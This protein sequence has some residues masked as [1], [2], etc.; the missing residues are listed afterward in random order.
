M[1]GSVAHLPWDTPHFYPTI[2]FISAISC[3]CVSTSGSG[4]SAGHRECVRSLNSLCVYVCVSFQ[5][6]KTTT[7]WQDEVEGAAV[8]LVTEGE[9]PEEGLV[10]SEMDPHV[11]DRQTSGN[12]L[13][14]T[15][16]SHCVAFNCSCMFRTDATLIWHLIHCT[17]PHHPGP[18]SVCDW[19]HF[20]VLCGSLF[21]MDV[22]HGVH[23]FSSE[24]ISRL[25]S[26]SWT[27]FFSQIVVTTLW[28]K[29]LH[30][31]VFP[32]KPNCVLTSLGC[33]LL[34]SLFITEERAQRP[35]LQLK[36]RTVSEPLNQVANPNSAI[37]GGA[38]PREEVISR[39]TIRD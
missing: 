32:K 7:T 15:S 2:P 38:K 27:A 13:K 25:T 34:S 6:L 17:C 20:H 18:S 36:P 29:P 37:F 33:C 9:E 39:Q 35:R 22:K 14:V 24:L 1:A 31:T 4:N 8:A 23:Y 3:L 16:P 12:L 11:E 26:V 28:W 21:A 10:A 5:V 19:P 30:L